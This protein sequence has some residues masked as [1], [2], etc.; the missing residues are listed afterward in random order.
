M[1][2]TFLA[3]T[4]TVVDDKKVYLGYPQRPSLLIQLEI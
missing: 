4:K 3:R 2:L 1:K